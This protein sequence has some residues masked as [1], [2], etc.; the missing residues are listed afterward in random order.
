MET[1]QRHFVWLSG[2]SELHMKTFML[3]SVDGT[4]GM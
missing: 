4:V 1:I 3:Q 2:M